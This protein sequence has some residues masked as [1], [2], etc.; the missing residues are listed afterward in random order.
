[1]P[2]PFQSVSDGIRFA[3]RLTPRGGRDAIEG[4]KTDSAGR[5]YLAARVRAAPED[6]KANQA[7]TALLAKTLG[8]PRA[9]VTIL[10]GAKAQLKI[11]SVQ[12]EPA[13]HAAK[14]R[15]AARQTDGKKI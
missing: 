13:A 11:V 7:L 5:E 4:W 1:L 10:S 3:V 8:V 14:L 2:A 12:G 15:Q 6:G 9:S